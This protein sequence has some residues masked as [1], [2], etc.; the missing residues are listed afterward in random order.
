MIHDKKHSHGAQ[1]AAGATELIHNQEEVLRNYVIFFPIVFSQLF[2][3][4]LQVVEAPTPR[5]L[6][7]AT[8]C[9]KSDVVLLY[10]VNHSQLVSFQ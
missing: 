4:L 5:S 2:L 1:E 9:C 3:Q 6:Q 10:N 7:P 8:E